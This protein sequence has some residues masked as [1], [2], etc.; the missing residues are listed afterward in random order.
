MLA[1]VVLSLV[2]LGIVARVSIRNRDD[3][4]ARGRE[5]DL[6]RE[7]VARLDTALADQETGQRGF[8]LTGLPQFLEPYT[9]GRA[10]EIRLVRA[11]RA[12]T[13]GIADLDAHVDAVVV[14]ARRWR[15][16]AAED[17]IELRSAG[18]TNAVTAAVASGE[19]KQ[20]FDELRDRSD[21]LAGAVVAEAREADDARTDAIRLLTV[22]VVTIIVIVLITI[23][24]AAFFIR[25][26][27]TVPID[28]LVSDVRRVRDGDLDAPIR[29]TG[30]PEI[31]ELAGAVDEMRTRIDTSR[32]AAERAREAVEQNAGVV[33]ALRS[34]LEPD[35]GDLPQGWT[36]AAELRAAEGVVAGD[37][38]DVAR[39]TGGRL[40]VVVV[41]IAGHGATEGVLA[42]RCKEMLRA[43]LAA[44]VE[45]GAAISAAAQQVGDMGPEVFLT[46][47]VAVVDTR[48]GTIR[49]ANAGHPP[50]YV[51]TASDAI[52]L[53]PTGPLVGLLGDAWGTGDA[54]MATG[55][56]LCAY[57]DGLVEVR[58]R[59]REFFGVQRLLDLIQGS[60][61][62][63]APTIVKRA[64]D[65][66]ELFAPGRLHDDATIVVLCRAEEPNP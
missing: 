19:G 12:R 37:C 35:V 62:D 11:L 40:G 3:A 53:G 26:W 5:A 33:L 66:I 31:A 58:N 32:V 65:E 4:I 64:L 20:L 2:G 23:G 52:E 25:R 47:F 17:E 41:D 38:Y 48:D 22:L 43:S 7:L 28:A 16:D 18:D 57:T 51:C 6:A 60:R 24:L 9:T 54:T 27:V 36:V 10:D 46:A 1:L 49:Y 39:I 44:G 34:Q 59:D 45:P 15:T 63:E 8:L 56:N 13:S 14:A 61:C 55:D 50:A 29:A 42:L 21:A 30:P